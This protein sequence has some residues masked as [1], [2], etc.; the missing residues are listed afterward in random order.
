MTE[1][2]VLG[3]EPRTVSGTRAAR[4]LRAAGKIPAILY[5]HKQG[6]VSI[7]VSSEEVERLVRRGA[8]VL[9]LKTGATVEK[10]LIRDLQWDHLGK[11][12]IHVDF[13]RV[14]ADER[15]EVTVPVELRGLAPGAINAAGVLNQPL[16]TLH[17]ECLATAIPESIR[18][19]ISALQ[20][21]QAIHVRELVL[22]EGL[23]VLAEPDAIVVQVSI[24][25][26]EVLPGEA[27]GIE[28][29]IITA[30]KKEK[31]DE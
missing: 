15:V 30:K 18:V 17:I 29:V 21:G 16:H 1:A 10:A 23:K 4:K 11:A 7:T 9:D 31:D 13:E 8:H 19:D 12:I 2:V 3:S 20:L 5:G 27:T 14:S 25:K 22:P 24:A 6:T 26:A 28:P